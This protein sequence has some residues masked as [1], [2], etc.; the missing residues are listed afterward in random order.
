MTAIMEN[1]HYFSIFKAACW[2]TAKQ[3]SGSATGGV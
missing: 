3:L 1:G 2:P